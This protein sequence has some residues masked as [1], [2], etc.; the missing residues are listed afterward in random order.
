MKPVRPSP[1]QVRKW[2]HSRSLTWRG[3]RTVFLVTN[4]AGFA[5]MGFFLLIYVLA[6]G[7]AFTLGLIWPM[8]C[9]LAMVGRS[10][11]WRSRGRLLLAIVAGMALPLYTASAWPAV[12]RATAWVFH[13]FLLVFV[14]IVWLFLDASRDEVGGPA[15]RYK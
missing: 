4:V 7:P 8:L 1:A 11:D 10:L 6:G 15:R 5:A 13:I 14:P 9:L 3:A 2:M 12:F